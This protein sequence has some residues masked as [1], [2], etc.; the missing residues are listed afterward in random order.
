MSVAG[1]HSLRG[2]EYQLLVAMHWLIQLLRPDAKIEWMQVESNGIA[3]DSNAVL[4]DDV[5][6][7]CQ[8]GRRC[9]MQVKKNHPR[10]ETWTIKD[11]D[12]RDEL[13]KAREQLTKN[14]QAFVLFYSRSPFGELKKLAENVHMFPGYTHFEQNAANNLKNT[15]SELCKLWNQ[16]EPQI[17]FDLVCRLDYAISRDFDEWEQA[18]RDELGRLVPRTAEALGILREMI[19]AYQTKL[20]PGL[21]IINRENVLDKLAQV[22]IYPTPYWDEQ[23]SL[24]RFATLRP[25]L[26]TINRENV[27][28]KLAQVGIY[29]TPYWDEQESLDR[30]A[31]ASRIG[32]KWFRDVDG[33][34]FTRQATTNLYEAIKQ[35]SKCIVL[36]DGPG[37]G[38]TCVLLDLMDRL[39]K[40][41]G[42]VPLFI[43]GD[44]FDAARTENDL[45]GRGLPDEMVGRCARLAENRQVVVIVDSLDVLALQRDHGALTLFLG[46]MDRLARIPELSVVAACRRFDLE[47]H[48]HL[49]GRNWDATVIIDSLDWQKDVVPILKIWGVDPEKLPQELRDLLLIPQ[50]LRLFCELKSVAIVSS[51]RSAHQLN[52]LF[53]RHLVVDDPKLGDEAMDALQKMAMGMMEQREKRLPSASWLGSGEAKRLLISKGIL[54]DAGAETIAFTHQTLRDN[55]LVRGVLEGGGDLSALINKLPPLPVVR[56]AIR[57]FVLHLVVVR[58]NNLGRQVNQVLSNQGVPYHIRRLIAETLAEIEPNLDTDWPWVNRLFRNNPEIFGR[59]FLKAYN[60]SWFRLLRDKWL[61]VLEGRSDRDRWWLEWLSRLYVWMNRFPAECLAWWLEALNGELEGNTRIVRYFSARLDEFTQWSLPDSRAILERL[62]RLDVSGQY[63]VGHLISHYV[64]ATNQ[65]DELLWN[66]ICKD[67]NPNNLNSLS[68]S[69]VLRCLPHHFHG[70]AF[71]EKRLL[72]SESLLSMAVTALEEWAVCL[73]EK[74]GGNGGGENYIQETSWRLSYKKNDDMHTSDISVLLDSVEKAMNRHVDNDTSWW[75]DNEPCLR[76]YRS[77][78]LRYL[79]I[80]AYI[81]QPERHKEGIACQLMDMQMLSRRIISRCIGKL[82]NVAAPYLER[83][84][85]DAYQQA[86]LNPFEKS[87]EEKKGSI[88]DNRLRYEQLVW[89]PCVFRTV[90]VQAFLDQYATVFGYA[91]PE[92]EIWGG[93]GWVQ[94]P[95]SVE[96]L[97]MLSGKG[98]IRFLRHYENFKPS[99]DHPGDWLIGGKESVNDVLREAAS[100]NPLR[101]MEILAEEDLEKGYVESIAEGVVS[102]VRY[103]FGNL[104]PANGWTPVEPLPS[105]ALLA[106]RLLNLLQWHPEWLWCGAIGAR[107]LEACADVLTEP[108]DT[109]QLTA[110][111]ALSIY[112]PDPAS[113]REQNDESLENQCINSARGIAAGAAACLAAKLLQS[114]SSLSMELISVL[115]QFAGDPVP[116]VRI[117]LLNAN[118]LAIIIHYQ[119][120]LGRDLFETLFREEQGALWDSAYHVFYYNYRRHFDWV[121]PCLE[122]MCREAPDK[123]MDSWARIVVLATLDGHMTFETLMMR[124]RGKNSEQAWKGA[125]IV[126]WKNL[127]DQQC[128]T[129]CVRGLEELLRLKSMSDTLF[130]EMKRG[131]VNK[132]CH[133]YIPVPLGEQFVDRIEFKDNHCEL[134]GFFSWL[135]FLSEQ[136]PLSALGLCERLIDRLAGQGGCQMWDT[137]DLFVTLTRLSREAD[138]GGDD[139][140]IRR[141]CALQNNVLQL[142]IWRAEEWLQQAESI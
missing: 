12:L 98:M 51:V 110:L 134:G 129:L 34:T 9:Y 75:R 43:R 14:P 104:Q 10:H 2:D 16:E 57:A 76:G 81:R 128:R 33:H 44:Y 74:K 31:T 139:S 114:G 101:Y 62:M 65:G 86:V 72:C 59:M 84:V 69:D 71:L 15:F 116:A 42:M 132:K 130:P 39:E 138:D 109:A 122:R 30:F 55:L 92:P 47:Y 133:P 142:G 48:T 50:N 121:E 123:S 82:V 13:K 91:L 4:V 66:F 88:H 111:F 3:E 41:P 125:A 83:E 6:V 100:I 26:H 70:D 99:Y 18:N 137:E 124:L 113:V 120:S 32:R 135:A 28:D 85:L 117:G 61:P 108:E 53:L 40:E 35:R 25:G 68:Y 67:V 97:N 36:T 89:I 115:K 56:P 112:N 24:D 73:M 136:D 126:F 106:R 119:P 131:F 29:P 45:T 27:L 77:S 90:D 1:T 118:L 107:I 105:A 52:D 127:V 80:Q 20:R 103:R 54:Y 21:H 37:T 58:P 46:L 17:A 141:V 60:D 95:I 5:V 19:T 78:A 49:R 102:H 7:G 11:S 79:L 63:Q 87:S 96:E 23:E 64:K 22:G 93:G 8:D 94:P 140:F 38:K